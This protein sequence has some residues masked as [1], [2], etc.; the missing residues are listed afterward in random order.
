MIVP[1][2]ID[3]FRDSNL[4]KWKINATLLMCSQHDI[5]CCSFF[6]LLSSFYYKALHSIQDENISVAPYSLGRQIKIYTIEHL[7]TSKM[8]NSLI[9]FRKMTHIQSPCMI[10][11][12]M[13]LKA[14]VG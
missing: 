11:A 8:A 9:F 1:T 12:N 5:T 6:I 14:N 4:S 10:S 2:K 7:A 13:F 3:L